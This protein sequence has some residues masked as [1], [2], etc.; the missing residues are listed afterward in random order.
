MKL[1]GLDTSGD[2]FLV[3]YKRIYFYKEV[4]VRFGK[5]HVAEALE[6]IPRSCQIYS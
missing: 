3:V 2:A 4:L 1:D 6:C 5:E